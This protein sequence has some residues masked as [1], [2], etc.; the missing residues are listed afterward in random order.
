MKKLCLLLLVCFFFS[1]GG[2]ANT[3]TLQ[4]DSLNQG[5]QTIVIHKC[6]TLVVVDL[7]NLT[8]HASLDTLPNGNA[9]HALPFN[10]TYVS[11]SYDTFIYN[12]FGAIPHLYISHYTSVVYFQVDIHDCFLSPCHGDVLITHSGFNYIFNGVHLS[13]DSTTTYMWTLNGDTLLADSGY[14]AQSHYIFDLPGVFPACLHVEDT[15]AHC[16]FDT[17]VGITIEIDTG[18]YTPLL[19]T[20]NWWYY[21]DN[22]IPVITHPYGGTRAQDCYDGFDYYLT[23]VTGIDTL[24]DN[25]LY[26]EVISGSGTQL[27]YFCRRGFIRE[28]TLERKVY[29]RDIHFNPE[30][31]LFNFGMLLGDTLSINFVSNSSWGAYFNSGVYRLD[32]ILPVQT[33]Q[34]MRTAY[35]LNC[36]SCNNNG[37]TLSWVKGIGCLGDLLY[38]YSNNSVGGNQLKTCASDFWNWNGPNFPYNFYKILIC[39]EHARKVYFDSCTLFIGMTNS[40]MFYQDSCHYGNQCGAIDEVSSLVSFT[41]SPN[42]AIDNAQIELEVKQGSHFGITVKDLD[43]RIVMQESN[44]GWL[45]EGKHNKTLTTNSLPGGIYLVGCRTD[46][47]TVYRRLVVQK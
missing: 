36:P 17:C 42:P 20:M 30:I 14:T 39:F 16:S 27:Q 18:A 44:L 23:D 33:P 22:V 4:I 13:P 5:R 8:V 19:D 15:A 46:E 37:H 38:P 31:L 7:T 34:G 9:N 40:C 29:F 24:I 28:D 35:Y 47:G 32:S 45:S 1:T 41:I 6:D 10:A 12:H 21:A 25:K 43:G 2:F 11:S 26:K 3:I